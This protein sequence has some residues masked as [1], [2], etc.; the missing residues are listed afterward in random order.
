MGG[1]QWDLVAVDL[2]GVL[3]KFIDS[4]M[5]VNGGQY[6]ES[7][8]PRGVWDIAP[9]MGLS[10]EQFWRSIDATPYFWERLQPYPWVRRIMELALSWGD[11]VILLST[12]SLHPSSRSGKMQWVYDHIHSL[13]LPGIRKV[14]LHLGA[15][16]HWLS[17]SGRMLID[18]NERN[19]ESWSDRGG[20]VILF[21]QPWNR[22]YEQR[23]ILFREWGIQK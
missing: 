4:A 1:K 5:R 23:E 14:E 13:D 12:P 9:H 15:K 7:A 18:D 22:A 19:C 2:D 10:D 8:Y 20:D 21:P 3:A 6:I 11:E 17:Q 16:K